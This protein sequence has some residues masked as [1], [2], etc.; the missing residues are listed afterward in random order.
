MF[1]ITSLSAH[2]KMDQ[3]Q[4]QEA[5]ERADHGIGGMDLAPSMTESIA[6]TIN[7]SSVTAIAVTSFADTWDSLVEKIK[8]FIAITDKF[9]EVHTLVANI[10]NLEAEICD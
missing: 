7:T 2:S 6:N 1:S 8:P 3:L 4:R 10:Q 5:I 9:A